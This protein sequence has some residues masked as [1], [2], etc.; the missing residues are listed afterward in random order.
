MGG[1]AKACVLQGTLRGLPARIQLDGAMAFDL[2]GDIGIGQRWSGE[3]LLRFQESS[4][5]K[6]TYFIASVP[7]SLRGA[8]NTS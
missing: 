6:G 8:S 5:S 3:F 7:A 1:Q 4:P 2:G